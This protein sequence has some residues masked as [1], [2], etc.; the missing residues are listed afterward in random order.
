MLSKPSANH[1]SKV[2]VRWDSACC[3]FIQCRH[4]LFNC[5][6]YSVFIH[7][8]TVSWYN[9]V[10]W[11]QYFYFIQWSDSNISNIGTSTFTLFS[12]H[13]FASVAKFDPGSKKNIENM[14]L[15]FYLRCWQVPRSSV[16]RASDPVVRVQTLARGILSFLFLFCFSHHFL[17]LLIISLYMLIHISF[18]IE[19]V[20]WFCSRCKIEDIHRNTNFLRNKREWVIIRHSLMALVCR[21]NECNWRSYNS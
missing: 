20:A 2:I 21:F 9:Y 5:C 13:F 12:I 17:S 8:S 4:S 19:L 6:L 16:G 11:L 18:L 14:S 10:T 1:C 7:L 3:V 15:Q